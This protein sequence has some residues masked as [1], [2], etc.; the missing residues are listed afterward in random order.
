M[1]KSGALTSQSPLLCT[2]RP[3]DTDEIG[4]LEIYLWDLGISD[5]RPGAKVEVND[6]ES[7]DIDTQSSV[8]SALDMSNAF[9]QPVT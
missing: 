8:L 4:G 9:R 3:I 1:R 6:D 2:N 7:E 5:D